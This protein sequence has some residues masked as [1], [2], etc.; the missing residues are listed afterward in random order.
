MRHRIDGEKLLILLGTSRYE[1]ALRFIIG[2]NNYIG[3][4]HTGEIAKCS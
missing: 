1:T 3:F 4:K 2:V